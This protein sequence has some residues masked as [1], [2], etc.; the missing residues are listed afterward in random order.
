M[1]FSNY[2]QSG[3]SITRLDRDIS[4]YICPWKKIG[5]QAKFGWTIRSE[6]IESYIRSL[7]YVDFVTNFSMLHI[8]QESDDR[9][10][11]ADTACPLPDQQPEG[12]VEWSPLSGVDNDDRITP[13]YPWSLAV[14]ARHHF[15]ETINS[16]RHI[17]AEPTGI[18]ELE[19]GT[20]FIIN[21]IH[22]R[23]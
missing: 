12:D 1:K 23:G 3:V 7:D 17:D 9:F 21:G 14:P 2:Q 15:I 4:S 11:L 16:I 6:D 22:S 13:R 18:G 8:T 10:I 5:Y 20:T 19:I